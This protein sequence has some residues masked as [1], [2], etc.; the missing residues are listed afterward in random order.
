[1]LVVESWSPVVGLVILDG[2]GGAS[3]LAERV[4]VVGR[5]KFVAAYHSVNMLAIAG[6]P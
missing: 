2:D 6:K 4:E 5:G 1:M 3:A